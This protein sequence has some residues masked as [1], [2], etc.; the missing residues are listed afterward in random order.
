M[1][2][3]AA[4]VRWASLFALLTVLILRP[5]DSS[6]GSDPTLADDLAA[7]E[8]TFQIFLMNDF[9]TLAGR[10][11]YLEDRVDKLQQDLDAVQRPLASHVAD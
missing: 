7:L 3:F 5:T 10:V 4:W 9:D 8:A 2:P 6:N 11:N 1:E